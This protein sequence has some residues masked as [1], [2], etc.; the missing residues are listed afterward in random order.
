M[1]N[2]ALA[3]FEGGALPAHVM[4]AN[5]TANIVPASTP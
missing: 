5:A 2:N 3:I 4:D 1:A